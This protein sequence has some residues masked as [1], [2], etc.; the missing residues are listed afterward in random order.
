VDTFNPLD[1]AGSYG[2]QEWIGTIGILKIEGS[3]NNVVGL[4]TAEVYAFL[5]EFKKNKPD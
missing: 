2:I 5:K 4:P 3:Y 1:K